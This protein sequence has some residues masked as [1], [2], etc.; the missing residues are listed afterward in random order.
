M[1][2]K[3]GNLAG[4]KEGREVEGAGVL[5]YNTSQEVLQPITMSKLEK[6]LESKEKN[7]VC[8]TN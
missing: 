1:G 6:I 2:L 5:S 3:E 8:K 7:M 4:R